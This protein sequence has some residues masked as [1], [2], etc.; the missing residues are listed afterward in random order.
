ML[1][2]AGQWVFFVIAA[3]LPPDHTQIVYKMMSQNERCVQQGQGE[4]NP[5]LPRGKTPEIGT[6]TNIQ[7]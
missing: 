4:P 7:L 6:R 2:T 3:L 5:S 1:G